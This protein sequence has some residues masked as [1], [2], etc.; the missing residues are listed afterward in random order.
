MLKVKMF[1]DGSVEDLEK[2]INA[3]L[4]LNPKITDVEFFLAKGS[5]VTVV[6]VVYRGKK[7]D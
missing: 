5:V 6:L 3:W 4:S 7:E 2:E 1:H